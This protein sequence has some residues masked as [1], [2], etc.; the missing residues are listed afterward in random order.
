MV[1][2]TGGRITYICLVGHVEV[3]FP[4]FFSLQKKKKEKEKGKKGKGKIGIK[5]S[6]PGQR[7]RARILLDERL[8]I[9]MDRKEKEKRLKKLKE[10]NLG[11]QNPRKYD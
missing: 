7:T 6:P 8:E 1:C 2:G 10:G 3:R 11:D 9:E 4:H 5:K